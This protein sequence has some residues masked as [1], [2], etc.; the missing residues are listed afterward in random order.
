VAG[1]RGS[2]D[3]EG[4]AIRERS[5]RRESRRQTDKAVLV[6]AGGLKRRTGIQMLCDRQ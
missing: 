4:R 6:D 1:G 3:F 5:Q 2:P